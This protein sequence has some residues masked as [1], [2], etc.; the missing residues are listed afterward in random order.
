MDRF[1][2][3]KTTGNEELLG[4]RRLGNGFDIWGRV[5]SQRAFE[6]ALGKL[7]CDDAFRREFCIDPDAATT[8]A[9]LKLTP[10]ELSS[11]RQMDM[12]AIEAFV[13]HVDDRVRRAEEPSVV[14]GA[15]VAR[16]R[17]RVTRSQGR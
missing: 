4:E 2:L 10:I 16:T 15:P 6:A 17:S 8:R 5:M 3:W 11:L 12:E 7:I 9:G 14:R 13:V 1:L